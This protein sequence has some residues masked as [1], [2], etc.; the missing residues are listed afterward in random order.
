MSFHALVRMTKLVQ[1]GIAT[2][3]SSTFRQRGFAI[4]AM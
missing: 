1:N 4:R 3:T 2:A